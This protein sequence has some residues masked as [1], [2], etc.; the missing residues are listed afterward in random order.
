MQSENR[1]D[2]VLCNSDMLISSRYPS[3]RAPDPNV[4]IPTAKLEACSIY[5]LMETW[6]EECICSFLYTLRDTG[7]KKDL[8][9]EKEF[10]T[11]LF[12]E[13]E[14]VWSLNAP[15]SDHDLIVLFLAT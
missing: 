6:E 13:G 10:N 8:R 14:N 11:T 7:F 15:E 4:N 9:Q 1:A 5:S 2:Q 12:K 3:H